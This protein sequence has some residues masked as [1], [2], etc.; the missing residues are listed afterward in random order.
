MIPRLSHFSFHSFGSFLCIGNFSTLHRDADPVEHLNSV[1][2]PAGWS[3]SSANL[4]TEWYRSNLEAR[5]AREARTRNRVSPWQVSRNGSGPWAGST[6]CIF[7]FRPVGPLVVEANTKPNEQCKAQV[8]LQR[9]PAVFTAAEQADRLACREMSYKIQKW[10]VKS[11]EVFPILLANARVDWLG[12]EDRAFCGM[13]SLN[14]P[15]QHGKGPLPRK[16]RSRYC[17]L[18]VALLTCG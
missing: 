8:P 17:C 9:D 14:V 7:G 3:K 6:R 11:A 2:L 13:C 1:G 4:V 15:L 18:D 16:S 10:N 12:I 5:E